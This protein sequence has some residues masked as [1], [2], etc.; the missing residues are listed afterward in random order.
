M[1]DRA[2]FL[3]DMERAGWQPISNMF[4]QI[5]TWAESEHNNIIT[6][7]YAFEFWQKHGQAPESL[8]F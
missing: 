7:E 3:L 5:T 4:N 1:N 2:Y 8:P 6:D